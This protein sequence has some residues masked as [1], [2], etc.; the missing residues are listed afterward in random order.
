MKKGNTLRRMLIA[1]G[2]IILL[3]AGPLISAVLATYIAEANGCVLNEGGVNPCIIGG[4]DWG[5][6]LYAMF[7]FGWVAIVTFQLGVAALLVWLVVAVI[8]IIRHVRGG[9]SSQSAA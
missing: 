1:L 2:I 4:V 9:S 6:A 7:V 8:L 3:T 5:Y